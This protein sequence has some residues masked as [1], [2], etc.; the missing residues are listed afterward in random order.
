[1]RVNAKMFTVTVD[2]KNLRYQCFR[3]I[4]WQAKALKIKQ[5]EIKTQKIC[6]STSLLWAQTERLL[7]TIANGWRSTGHFQYYQSIIIL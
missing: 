2:F 6:L 1:M 5:I 7:E 4:F 3:M